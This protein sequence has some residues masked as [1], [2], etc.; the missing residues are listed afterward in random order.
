ML[1]A[2]PY[3]P[4][5]REA[6]SGFLCRLQDKPK[7]G[8]PCFCTR[9]EE[10]TTRISPL[11]FKPGTER[12]RPRRAVRSAASKAQCSGLGLFATPVA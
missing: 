5:F 8:N 10:G 6:R 7:V 12:A 4:E 9:G 3:R 1:D 11:Q 2:V